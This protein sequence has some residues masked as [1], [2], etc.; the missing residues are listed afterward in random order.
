MFVILLI[1]VWEFWFYGGLKDVE[2]MLVC[3]LDEQ[4]WVKLWE[5][6]FFMLCEFKSWVKVFDMFVLEWYVIVVELLCK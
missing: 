2:W 3:Y 6:V 4:L 1:G 5:V